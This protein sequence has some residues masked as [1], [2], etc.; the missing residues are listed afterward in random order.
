MNLTL[1]WFTPARSDVPHISK[2][3][4]L[5]QI[6]KMLRHNFEN[7][8]VISNVFNEQIGK[9]DIDIYHNKGITGHTWSHA[10]RCKEHQQHQPLNDLAW[11][12]F[13]QSLTK[14]T[15]LT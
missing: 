3:L 6:I 1:S 11:I 9:I 12:S 7:Q 4:R 13:D 5:Q 10:D 14:H 15:P 8:I 2:L